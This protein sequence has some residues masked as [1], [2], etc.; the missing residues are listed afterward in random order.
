[1]KGDAFVVMRIRRKEHLEPGVYTFYIE[2]DNGKLLYTAKKRTVFWKRLINHTFQLLLNE[3]YMLY[4]EGNL[5]FSFKQEKQRVWIN[6][7][8]IVYTKKN[9]DK[10]FSWQSGDDTY[11]FFSRYRTLVYVKHQDV[12]QQLPFKRTDEWISIA[13]IVIDGAG[14]DDVVCICLLYINVFFQQNIGGELYTK[15]WYE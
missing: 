12:V 2:A 14:Y 8:E 9:G 11:E 3:T 5:A 4:E 10:H 13:D 6:D 7:K 1:M 15:P